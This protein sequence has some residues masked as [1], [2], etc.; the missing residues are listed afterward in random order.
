M[1]DHGKKL[2][3]QKEF[4]A[5][6]LS[7]GRYHGTFRSMKPRFLRR[8]YQQILKTYIPILS[9]HGNELT[10]D[11]VKWQARR[12]RLPVEPKHM[13]AYKL[14]NGKFA[15]QVNEKGEFIKEPLE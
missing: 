5:L 14:A 13:R 2:E 3:T 9:V 6:R 12:K 11:H 15:G 10:I 8:R 4:H 7:S 1:V